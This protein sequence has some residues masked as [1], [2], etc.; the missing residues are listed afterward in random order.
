M[1][2]AIDLRGDLNACYKE[3]TS[4]SNNG[5]H[6]SSHA[7]IGGNKDTELINDVK[8]DRLISSAQRVRSPMKPDSCWWRDTT[9]QNKKNDLM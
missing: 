4:T 6:A 8:T 1:T 7:V 2:S 5:G 9:L 3:H